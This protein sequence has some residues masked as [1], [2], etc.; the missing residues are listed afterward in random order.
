MAAL[1]AA[2]GASQ[3]KAP[4]SGCKAG[5]ASEEIKLNTGAEGERQRPSTHGGEGE[6]STSRCHYSFIRIFESSFP[7]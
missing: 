5:N 6:I 3:S 7:G 1:A 4:A 2:V